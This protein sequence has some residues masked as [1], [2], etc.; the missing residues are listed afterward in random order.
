MNTVNAETGL[1]APLLA[2]EQEELV[3]LVDEDEDVLEEGSPM[4][5]FGTT[6]WD[7]VCTLV[8]V[9]GLLWLQFM[10]AFRSGRALDLTVSSVILTI[11]LYS[12]ASFMYKCCIADHDFT[13]LSRPLQQAVLLLPEILMDVVLGIVLFGSATTAFEGLLYF[14]MVL[15]I[16]VIVSTIS[17]LRTECS[18]SVKDSDKGEKNACLTQ[19]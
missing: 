7:Y 17:T 11:A 18:L 5:E 15:A 2:E 16:F 14:T 12:S 13:A 6:C 19:V 1:E 8:V 9:P 3:E 4:E 10:V